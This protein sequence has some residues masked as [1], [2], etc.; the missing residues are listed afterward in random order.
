MI[1]RRTQSIK[2]IRQKVGLGYTMRA[3]K[4]RETWWFIIIPVFSKYRLIDVNVS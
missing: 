3:V 2:K 4:V 1:I